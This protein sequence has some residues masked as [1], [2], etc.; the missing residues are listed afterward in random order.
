LLTL[1]LQADGNA[2]EHIDLVN[3]E[4]KYSKNEKKLKLDFA[5]VWKK[6]EE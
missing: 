5:S 3:G 4:L 1:V 6:Y 2:T